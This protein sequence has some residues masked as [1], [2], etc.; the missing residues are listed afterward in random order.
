MSEKTLKEL[1]DI[2]QPNGIDW[3]GDK[4]TD[5]NPITYHHIVKK[6]IINEQNPRSATVDRKSYS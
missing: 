3:L 5:D 4:I 6:E 2:F 1:I